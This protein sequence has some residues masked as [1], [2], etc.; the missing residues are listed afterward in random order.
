M[1]TIFIDELYMFSAESSRLSLS[2]SGPA[3]RHFLLPE[4]PGSNSE[5]DEVCLD[6]GAIWSN[7]GAIQ[8]HILITQTQAASPDMKSN[9]HI[10]AKSL[11]FT[12]VV[13]PIT[14]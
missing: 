10:V 8:E 14:T 4:K 6:S 5:Q 13:Q 12:A 1:S 9:K 2:V 3:Q 7:P 11:R